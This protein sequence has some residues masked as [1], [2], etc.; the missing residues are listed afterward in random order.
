MTRTPTHSLA[1]R[2][3]TTM[4]CQDFLP[5]LETGGPLKRFKAKR[6]AAA[7]PRCAAI[8]GRLRQL[9]D[10]LSRGTP[11]TDAQRRKWQDALPPLP[12]VAPES[13]RSPRPFAAWPSRQLA[14][15][16]A[17]AAV[18]LLTAGVAWQNGFFDRPDKQVAVEPG[19]HG[20]PIVEPQPELPLYS[21][22]EIAQLRTNFSQLGDE[23]DRLNELT[24]LLD[25]R[26]EVREVL[27]TYRQ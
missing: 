24:Q 10:E 20:D 18:L 16:A 7:C 25:A 13:V 15:A 6:H 14:W 2:A 8:H 12:Q 9:K 22:G 3:C 21:G 5:N 17:G 27:L 23:L 11:L 1:H 26:H 4:N 19:E